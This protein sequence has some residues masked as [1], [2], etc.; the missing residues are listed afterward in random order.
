LAGGAQVFCRIIHALR[1]SISKR[2]SGGSL[3]KLPP[4]LFFS[5]SWNSSTT[6]QA[7]DDLNFQQAQ[8]FSA[9][10][11]A[12]PLLPFQGQEMACHSRSG[13]R[14]YSRTRFWRCRLMARSSKK[15][16]VRLTL[17]HLPNLAGQK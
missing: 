3:D 9:G 8:T 2:C 6:P 11:S 7:S 5:G 17:F 16:G 1:R 13:G 12:M 15:R 10:E 4:T 14:C